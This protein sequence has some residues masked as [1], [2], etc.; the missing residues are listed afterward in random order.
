MRTLATIC[1]FV[2]CLTGAAQPPAIAADSAQAISTEAPAGE[3][4]LDRAHAS[5]IFRVDHLGFSMFTARFKD[6]SADLHFDPAAPAR[7]RLAA[8]VDARSI[9]TDYPD[10][11]TLDFNAQLQGEDWLDAARHPQIAFRSTAFKHLGGGRFR[12]E[13]MLTLRGVTRPIVM[14]GAFNGGYAGH[15]L[16]PQARIG[17]SAQTLLQ[18]SEFG[19]TI[20]IPAPGSKLGVGDEVEVLIEAEFNGPAWQLEEVAASTEHAKGQ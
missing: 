18:R 7:S 9:E 4:R 10:P 16:D 11:A 2:M 13:G 1:V 15:L 19:M 6:F 12:V 14:N 17:F 20:G 3:Y 5:L 8:T